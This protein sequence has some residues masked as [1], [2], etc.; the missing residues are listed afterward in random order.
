M[1]YG[2]LLGVILDML[3][4]LILIIKS[5]ISGFF[6][7]IQFANK[8]IEFIHLPSVCKDTFIFSSVSTCLENKNSLIICYKYNIPISTS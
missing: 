4:N 8:K 5:F 2:H 7:R 3:F 1:A 6:I